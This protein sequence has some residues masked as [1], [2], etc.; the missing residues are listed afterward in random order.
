M[1]PDENPRDLETA[2]LASYR[3]G[4]LEG[5]A[6]G[7]GRARS[8]YAAATDVVK[9]AEM[10]NNLCVILIRLGRGRMALEAVEGTHAVFEQAGHPLQAARAVGNW[11]AA[12]AA[13]GRRQ[14]AIEGYED[15]I[16]RFHA[17]GARAEEADTLQALSRLHLQGGDPMAAAA[18]AQVAVDVHPSPG[19]IRR[20]ARSIINRAF[21]LLRI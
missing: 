11:A 21:G 16:R 5:A 17:L 8:A 19:P 10:G 7:F 1:S 2:A 12:L 4:D 6:D 18:T 9:A 3:K 15:A 13:S 20:L 14:E